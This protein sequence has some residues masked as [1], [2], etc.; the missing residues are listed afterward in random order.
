MRKKAL[1][2][3]FLDRQRNFAPKISFY[4]TYKRQN[5]IIPTDIVNGHR[6]PK[7][8]RLGVDVTVE[9]NTVAAAL[10]VEGADRRVV[11]YLD[12]YT[13]RAFTYTLN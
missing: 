12:T 4:K 2:Q 6:D 1:F 13:M 5:I 10:H 3:H 9:G 11:G 7:E 8:G